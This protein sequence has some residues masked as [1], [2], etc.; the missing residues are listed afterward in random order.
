MKARVKATGEIIEVKEG[1]QIIFKDGSIG[2]GFRTDNGEILND[3]QL[4]FKDV[5]QEKTD[6]K[7]KS[8]P[9]DEPD[10]WDKLKH[11]YAGMAMQGIL[12]NNDLLTALCDG[13]KEVPISKIVL[14][15]ADIIATALVNRFKEE[16]K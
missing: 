11:Q 9:K 2:L 14:D 15:N 5:T 3:Y 10:Y 12:S 1:T 13:N 7:E 16:E 8:L 6:V 4:D